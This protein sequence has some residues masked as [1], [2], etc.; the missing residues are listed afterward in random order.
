MSAVYRYIDPQVLLRAAGGDLDSFRS[1][2]HTFVAIAPP[3]LQRL[4]AALVAGEARAL[5]YESHALKGTVGLVGAAALVA[6]LQQLESAAGSSQLAAAASLCDGLALAFAQVLAEV[7]RSI[8]EFDGGVVVASATSN[9]STNANANA[10]TNA[11]N[12]TAT[13]TTA[14]A[15]V[16][17][18]TAPRP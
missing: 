8:A 14:T 6:A 15:V 4:Q 3:M 18:A 9:T 2:A 17:T 5:C 1:L 13:A 10:N 16:T 12:A 7:E 11:T